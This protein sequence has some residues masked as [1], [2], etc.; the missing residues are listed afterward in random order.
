MIVGNGQIASALKECD[1]DDVVYF[2]SGVSDSTCKDERAFDKEK[3]LLVKMLSNH[4]D[5][6]FIYFSSCVITVPEYPKNVYYRHKIQMEEIIKNNTENYYIFRLPQL[7]GK[8]KKH[9]TLINFI[10]FSIIENKSF[11]IY[12]NAYR[13]VLEIDDLRSFVKYYIQLGH[14][15]DTVDLANDYRYSVEEIVKVFEKLLGKKAKYKLVEKTDGYVLDLKS[16]KGFIQQHNLKLDFGKS[17][18][19]EKLKIHL[20]NYEPQM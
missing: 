17:Y 8:L 7:F 2:A 1:R 14:S 9:K 5:K 19:M 15:G 3:E 6:T 16:M 11:E 12:K 10:Y 4:K 13:Y 20:D 18:L